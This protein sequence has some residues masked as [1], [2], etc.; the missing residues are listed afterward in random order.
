MLI[1]LYT[2]LLGRIYFSK[3]YHKN[4]YH[5]IQVIMLIIS[6]DT[7]CAKY[8]VTFIEFIHQAAL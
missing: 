3:V 5:K 8:L 4:T 2:M 1:Y 6:F 7:F